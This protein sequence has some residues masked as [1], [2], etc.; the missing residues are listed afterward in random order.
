MNLNQKKK[1]KRY[2]E[3]CWKKSGSRQG[4][5][6][7]ITSRDATVSHRACI[8]VEEPRERAA[9]EPTMN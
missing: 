9:N 2:P 5:C 8:E 7:F 1:I 4:H 3:V 6:M